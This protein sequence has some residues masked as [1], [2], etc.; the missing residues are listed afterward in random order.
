MHL[1]RRQV[2]LSAELA[3]KKKVASVVDLEPE[4]AAP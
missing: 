3:E 4:L 2:F 1:L